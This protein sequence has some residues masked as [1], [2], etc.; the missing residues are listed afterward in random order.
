VSCNPA[1]RKILLNQKN[2]LHGLYET[3]E[4]NMADWQLAKA[5]AALYKMEDIFDEIERELGKI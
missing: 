2:S 1:F 3:V 5:D 4:E